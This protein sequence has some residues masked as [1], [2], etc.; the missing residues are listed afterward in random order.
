MSLSPTV[1]QAFNPPS[2]AVSA[3]P[4][5]PEAVY[6]EIPRPVSP[7]TESSPPSLPAAPVGA[8]HPGPPSQ[9]PAQMQRFPSVQSGSVPYARLYVAK[10][11]SL[12]LARPPLPPES[13]WKI[14]FVSAA[15]DIAS[16][17]L[18]IH[19]AGLLHRDL[20]PR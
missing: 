9:T 5:P 4:V 3:P 20:S 12:P 17:L 11:P 14:P 18:A 15:T 2:A 6:D 13:H 7:G 1:V 16:G 10:P 8:E 19:E